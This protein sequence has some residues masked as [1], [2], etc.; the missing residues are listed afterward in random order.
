MN[1]GHLNIHPK[2]D[3]EVEIKVV[4]YPEKLAINRKENWQTFELKVGN[5]SLTIF[6]DTAFG[7]IH[8]KN[9]VLWAFEAW[10]RKEKERREKDAKE[11]TNLR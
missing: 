11:S 4:D 2:G 5:F 10:E 1:N 8:L 7:L 3:W 6:T 9:Q